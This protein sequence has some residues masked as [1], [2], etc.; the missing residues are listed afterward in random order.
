MSAPPM[1]PAQRANHGHLLKVWRLV[2]RLK[3]GSEKLGGQAI[4]LPDK[5]A[6]DALEELERLLAVAP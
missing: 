4:S 3:T 5:E 1:T 6:A 2:R